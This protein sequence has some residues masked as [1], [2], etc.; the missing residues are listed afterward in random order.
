MDSPHIAV[1]KN[2]S[3]KIGNPHN[4]RPIGK[5]SNNSLESSILSDTKEEVYNPEPKTDSLDTENPH[6]EVEPTE[7]SKTS[8]KS[9]K[10][11][12][13]QN[14]DELIEKHQRNSESRKQH[15]PQSPEEPTD[16]Q[17]QKG[18]SSLDNPA[19]TET[20]GITIHDDEAKA[21]IN[22][23]VPYILFIKKGKLIIAF[24]SFK[25]KKKNHRK[26]MRHLI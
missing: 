24:L 18:N 7:N 14:T 16:T 9:L 1:T 25:H 13:P 10:V 2:S 6:N 26:L 20:L 21:N 22:F 4:V 12:S 5:A 19:S 3:P 11:G 23:E 15:N 17:T 8:S